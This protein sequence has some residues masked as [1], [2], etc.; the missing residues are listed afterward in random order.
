V[1][2][3][4][5]REN[6][7]GEMPHGEGGDEGHGDEGHGGSKGQIPTFERFANMMG[8]IVDGPVTAFRERIVEPIQG[9]NKSYYY[10]RRYRR[11]PTIDECYVSDPLCKYEAHEQFKRDKHVDDQILVILR[12]RRLECE[13][14][15]GRVDREKYCQKVKED[16]ITAETNWFTKYGDIGPNRNVVQA[17]MKQKHRMLWERRHGPVGTGMKEESVH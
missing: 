6:S 11:V 5:G 14:F 16:Y 13:H 1:N 7:A 3:L 2:K 9:A 12:Q 15:H 10:H 8:K 4:K 17:Y